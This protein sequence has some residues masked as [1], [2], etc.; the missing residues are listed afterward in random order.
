MHGT[1]NPREFLKGATPP[2]DKS[3]LSRAKDDAL[4]AK[5]LQASVTA[6]LGLGELLQRME[7]YQAQ[8]RQ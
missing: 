8:K 7:Q 2:T 5:V 6:A 3:V 1:L 4:S